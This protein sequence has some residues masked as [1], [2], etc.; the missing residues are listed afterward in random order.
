M[1]LYLNVAIKKRIQI[2]ELE[3]LRLKAYCSAGIYKSAN[4]NMVRKKSP[5][6]ELKKGGKLLLYNSRFKLFGRGS[7]R[8]GAYVVG[9]RT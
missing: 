2:S 3:K 1:N 7:K 9:V 8:D 6:N 5:K 4:K